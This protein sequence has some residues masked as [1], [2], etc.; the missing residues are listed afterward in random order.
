MKQYQEPQKSQPECQLTCQPLGSQRQISKRHFEQEGNTLQ[1]VC[2]GRTHN[3]ASSKAV[4]SY[5][6]HHCLKW[7]AGLH[8]CL[9]TGGERGTT[10]AA[11]WSDRTGKWIL[12]QRW[13]G[14]NSGKVNFCRTE[15]IVNEQVQ[16]VWTEKMSDFHH[17][18]Q[19]QK[20]FILRWSLF[21][22]SLVLKEFYN[23][24]R[25]SLL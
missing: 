2:T 14:V 16:T 13:H 5:G 21:I 1:W 17:V 8:L 9:G 20:F 6:Q 7:R 10:K 11:G 22:F 15:N 4:D 18:Q 19:K 25:H 24:L 3:T 12:Q 23:S